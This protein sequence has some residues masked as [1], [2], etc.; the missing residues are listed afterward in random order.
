MRCNKR[1][2]H[3]DLQHPTSPGITPD[4]HL[5][6][7][8]PPPSPP[9]SHVPWWPSLPLSFS[10]AGA[11]CLRKLSGTAIPRNAMWANSLHIQRCALGRSST[12]LQEE[13]AATT[14]HAAASP[15]LVQAL[16]TGWGWGREAAGV[17]IRS[18]DLIFSKLYRSSFSAVEESL[19]KLTACPDCLNTWCSREKIIQKLM[20]YRKLLH[21]YLCVSPINRILNTSSGSHKVSSCSLDFIKKC[22]QK[23]ICI[24]KQKTALNF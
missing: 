3:A 16:V 1:I 20:D 8:L 12:L 7:Q 2:T 17:R 18:R 21:Q 13:R 4:C 23:N 15:S 10:S 9:H 5:P 24:W 19:F 6:L 22:M 11:Q 14:R